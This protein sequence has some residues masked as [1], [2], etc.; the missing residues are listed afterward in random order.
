M[1]KTPRLRELL[2]EIKRSETLLNF[3]VEQ[4]R[5]MAGP[6]PAAPWTDAMEQLVMEMLL[7]RATAR[8]D[9]NFERSDAYRHVLERV[10]LDV[11]ALDDELRGP[12][13]K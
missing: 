8:M 13:R 11:T 10:G 7:S 9:R 5:K 1:D 12:M 4:R 6:R 3:F 2:G